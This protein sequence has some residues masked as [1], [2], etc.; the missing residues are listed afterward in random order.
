MPSVA[1]TPSPPPADVHVAGSGRFLYAS[2]R[3]T[4]RSRCSRSIR[5][6]ASCRRCSRSRAAENLR[7]LFAGPDGA[8][9]GRGEAEVRHDRQLPCRR[10]IWSPNANRFVGRDGMT[11]KWVLREAANRDSSVRA[12]SVNRAGIWGQARFETTGSAGVVQRHGD[13]RRRVSTHLRRRRSWTMNSSSSR[14]FK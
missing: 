10:R 6:V 13:K 5:R 8:V 2:N 1:V 14:P 9:S 3:A 11:E 7:A 4:T 12:L